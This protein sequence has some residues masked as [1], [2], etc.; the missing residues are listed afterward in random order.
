MSY[1]HRA[2]GGSGLGWTTSTP[3]GMTRR[4]VLPDSRA[5]VV[6]DGR[7]AMVIIRQPEGRPISAADE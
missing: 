3:P 4:R 7:S 6:C 5:Q 1:F 2:D